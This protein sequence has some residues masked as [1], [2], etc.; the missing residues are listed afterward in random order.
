MGDMRNA[1]K[2]LVSACKRKRPLR[3]YM[4]V[5][6]RAILKWVLKKG[7]GLDSTGSG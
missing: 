4:C 6:K 2:I 5:D 7:Y 3:T 1:Y